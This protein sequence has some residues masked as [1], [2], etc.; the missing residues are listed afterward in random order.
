[1]IDI[2]AAAVLACPACHSRLEAESENQ[3][4]CVGCAERYQRS[5][6]GFW[7]VRRGQVF[8]DWFVQD[9]ASGDRFRSGGACCEHVG[10]RRLIDEYLVPLLRRLGLQ[11]GSAVGLS[12]GCG[13]GADVERLREHGYLAWGGDPGFRSDLWTQRKCAPYLVHLDGTGL[14]SR[15]GTFDFVLSE[16]VIEHVGIEG[17]VKPTLDRVRIE[18][19]RAAYCAEMYRVL[20]PGGYAIIAAP[21]R[22]FPID[23]FHGGR[24]FLGLSARF[25]RPNELFLV[26][27]GQM[28]RWFADFDC[29]I[30]ALSLR[31]FF[32]TA[33]LGRQGLPGQLAQLAWGA[34]VGVLP[35]GAMARIGPYFVLLVR[36]GPKGS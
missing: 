16:G 34:A 6:N 2:E 25:H 4:R 20:K 11:P 31:G 29:R 28:R 33:Y 21:N 36:K 12:D 10:S 18:R 7:D 23:F 13:I 15:D 5:P 19:D 27:A 14:P 26:S 30:A 1:M 24:P 9:E 22:L 35:P 3:V 8:K 32:N 17:D